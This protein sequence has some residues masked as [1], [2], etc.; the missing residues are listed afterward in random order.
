MSTTRTG[1]ILLATSIIADRRSTDFPPNQMSSS[2]LFRASSGAPV[3][4]G[5][6]GWVLAAFAFCLTPE[7]FAADDVHTTL[8]INT[9][10]PSAREALIESIEAEGLVV[11]AVIPFG[12]MLERTAGGLGKGVSPFV[13]AEIVQF[14]SARL[15]RQLVEED[16]TQIALCPLSIAVFATRVAPGQ[17]AYAYHSLGRGSNG[18]IGASNLLEKLVGRAA[19]LA[20]LR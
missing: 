16:V 19:G 10:F 20:R 17:I 9:D 6:L 2:R 7:A 15:A 1:T 12:G 3:F 11:S 14:C 4:F 8:L 5:I 13:D 18:R